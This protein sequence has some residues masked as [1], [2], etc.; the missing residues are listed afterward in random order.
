MN[1]NGPPQP[2]AATL[3]L[4]NNLNKKM[5]SKTKKHE[6]LNNGPPQPTQETLKMWAEQNKKKSRKNKSIN[7]IMSNELNKFRRG[8]L[9]HKL[10]DPNAKHGGRRTWKRRRGSRRN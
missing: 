7:N 10:F 9:I 5:R 8:A 1:N 4:L 3:K 6:N 2:N